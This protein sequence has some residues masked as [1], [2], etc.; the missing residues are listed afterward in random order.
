MG[1]NLEEGWQITL[2]HL[3]AAR[4]QLP[5]DLPA[6]VKLECLTRYDECLSANELE[7]AFDELE[8]FGIEVEGRHST[9]WSELLAA[10]EEMSLPEHAERC[11][12][13]LSGR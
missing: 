1:K 6:S 12:Q 7:L 4:A 13:R 3:E 5:L 2:R 10:A 8:E 9:F 11:R